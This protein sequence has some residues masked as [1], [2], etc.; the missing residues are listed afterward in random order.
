MIL[1][2]KEFPYEVRL[3]KLGLWS[4]EDRRIRAGLIEVFKII[5][6]LTSAHS[7]NIPH[8][9]EQEDIIIIVIIFICSD[10]NI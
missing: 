3:E 8:M 9:K 4:L 1:S 6:G 2:I 10:K 5:H 7:S